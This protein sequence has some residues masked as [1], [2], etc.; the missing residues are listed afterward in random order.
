MTTHADWATGLLTKHGLRRTQ[1]RISL[2][3]LLAAQERPVSI[4]FL[5]RKLS[6]ELDPVTLYRALDAFFRE[7]IVAR[8]DFGHGHTHYEL[9][10]G[11]P[12]HHHAV[13]EQCGRIEDV[14]A[15]HSPVHAGTLRGVPS[16]SSFTR[17][18][19]EFYGLCTSCAP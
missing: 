14:P 5:Q 11:R 2:L 7:G 8:F 12:H 4:E 19:L 15:G 10:Q 18:S 13:C 1:G 17:H 9:A 16:F 6:R 3:E